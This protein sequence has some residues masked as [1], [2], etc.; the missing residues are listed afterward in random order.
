VGGDS[1][2]LHPL[3]SMVFVISSARLTRATVDGKTT[4]LIRAVFADVSFLIRR[5]QLR[6]LFLH[7]RRELVEV[8]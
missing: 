7:D 3:R 6:I 2:A 8:L 1:R 4:G 5:S